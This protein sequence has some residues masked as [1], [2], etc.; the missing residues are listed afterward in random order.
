MISG[1]LLGFLFCLIS[2]R[3]RITGSQY[4]RTHHGSEGCSLSLWFSTNGLG[5]FRFQ[6]VFPECGSGGGISTVL[7]TADNWD[8]IGSNPQP[9]RT[10]NGIRR[11]TLFTLVGCTSEIIPGPRNVDM[12]AWQACLSLVLVGFFQ[13]AEKPDQLPFRKLSFLRVM[14][15]NKQHYSLQGVLF[16]CPE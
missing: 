3:V 4:A 13:Q 11:P 8:F 16:D 14:F 2:A 10:W 6:H 1:A 12:I 5:P 7:G 9:P 15:K